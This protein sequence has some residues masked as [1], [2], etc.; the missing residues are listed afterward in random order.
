MRV[1][2]GEKRHLLLKTVDSDQVR[3]TTDKIKETLFN[4]IQFKLQDIVFVDLYAGSGAIGIEALSRG[5][6]KAYFIDNNKFAINIIKE[7]LNNT[8]LYDKSIVLYKDAKNA[9]L[10]LDEINEKIDILFMDPPYDKDLYYDCFKIL[11]ETNII[12]E[13]TVIIIETSLEDNVDK[14]CELGFEITR[15]KEYK[16]QKHTFL[17]KVG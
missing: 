5:A 4:I 6:K 12:K 8:K 3:P 10:Y 1:I 7:N 14:V 15:I 16:N 2:A 11:K 9:L 17:K 13:D